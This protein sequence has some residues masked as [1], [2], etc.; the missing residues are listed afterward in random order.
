MK[1]KLA[2]KKKLLCY[3]R[4]RRTGFGGEIA[5]RATHNGNLGIPF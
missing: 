4:G 5:Q 2:R 3:I 1:G